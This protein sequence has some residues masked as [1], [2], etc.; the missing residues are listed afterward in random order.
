MTTQLL[1]FPYTTGQSLTTQLFV[2]GSDT[3]AATAANV[4]EATNRKGRYIAEFEDVPAG[5]YLLIY[6][7]DG[8]GAGSENYKLTL[9]DA[10]FQPL[11]ESIPAAI[12]A[13]AMASPIHSNIKQVDDEHVKPIDEDKIIC[14]KKLEVS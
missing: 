13:A 8:I 14:K 10:T 1:E 2:V 9:D 6:F 4:T 11:A 5:E 12:L 3:V 7:L